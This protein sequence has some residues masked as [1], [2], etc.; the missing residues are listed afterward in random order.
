MVKVMML[1]SL[2]PYLIM[3][4]MM[5]K[6]LNFKA[7]GESDDDYEYNCTS[8][9]DSNSTDCNSLSDDNSGSTKS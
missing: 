6:K 4:V 7:Y 1:K 3:K 2:T 9:D 8:V 5:L